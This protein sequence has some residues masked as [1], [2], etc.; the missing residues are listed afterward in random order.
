[1]P[2]FLYGL[3]GGALG[4]SVI[5]LA[6]PEGGIE[7]LQQ[8]EGLVPVG[9]KK[10]R[11]VALIWFTSIQWFFFSTRLRLEKNCGGNQDFILVNITF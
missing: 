11:K 10:R 1:M 4:G 8:F 9:K 2:N 3:G 5:S 7:H 6:L